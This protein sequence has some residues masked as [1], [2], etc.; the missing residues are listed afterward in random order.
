MTFLDIKEN[1]ISLSKCKDTSLYI[2]G[3]YIWLID[4]YEVFWKKKEKDFK[5]NCYEVFAMEKTHLTGYA[6]NLQ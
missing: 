6:A 2:F 3:R 5:G 1:R 4:Y